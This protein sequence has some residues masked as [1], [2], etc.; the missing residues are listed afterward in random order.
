[1]AE[2]RVAINAF[3][4]EMAGSAAGEQF[5]QGMITKYENTVA[6]LQNVYTEHARYN[7]RMVCEYQ[8]QVQQSERERDSKMEHA[9]LALKEAQR[10]FQQ[11]QIVAH[12]WQTTAKAS[13]GQ[14]YQMTQEYHA[15]MKAV[16]LRE[17]HAIAE[18]RAEC[19]GRV[20]PNHGYQQ[21]IAR[22]QYSEIV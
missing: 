19:A 13:S 4:A 20:T 9:Q 7:E 12:Q 2:S 8:V 5:R 6:G 1:M 14:V 17:Q 15:E 22:A 21:L 10:D 3:N 16:S 11:A 18:V